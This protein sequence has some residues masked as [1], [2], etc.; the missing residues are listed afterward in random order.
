MNF[1][2]QKTGRTLICENPGSKK[3]RNL[4]ETPHITPPIKFIFY[5]NP[6][7][8]NAWTFI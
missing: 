1:K 2:L 6:F 5:L 7:F 8:E 3:G 4:I